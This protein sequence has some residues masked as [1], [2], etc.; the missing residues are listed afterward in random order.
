M[1]WPFSDPIQDL[2][3]IALKTL[4]VSTKLAAEGPSVAVV[5]LIPISPLPV[6]T[7]CLVCL[8]DPGPLISPT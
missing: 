4:M 5:L 8:P 7:L 1:K 3:P 6:L 2:N